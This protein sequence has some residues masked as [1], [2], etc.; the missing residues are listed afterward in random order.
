MKPFH[1]L[2]RSGQIARY[3]S[4]AEQ[5]LMHYELDAQ[6]IIPLQ[7]AHNATFRIDAQGEADPMRFALRIQHPRLRSSRAINSELHWLQAIAQDTKLVVPKPV[8]NKQGELITTIS[9]EGI[10][11]A[12]HCI[13]FEWVYGI[14]FRSQL[15]VAG[16]EQAGE[17]MA[18]LHNHATCYSPPAWFLRQRWDGQGLLGSAL[19]IDIQK[20][21]NELSPSQL[22]TLDTATEQIQ[23]ITQELGEGPEVFNLI[24]ADFHEANYLFLNQKIRA[25]DFDSCG[26][27]YYLYDIGVTFSTLQHLPN[28]SALRAAFLRGYRHIR[29]LP[30]KHEECIQ[31]FIGARLLG[32]ILLLAHHVREPGF[33]RAAQVRIDHQVKY[34][35]ALLGQSNELYTENE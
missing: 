33:R 4:L 5:T 25:I 3:R 20:S 17:F 11:E 30:L 23:Q 8:P 24:H 12:R 14:F 29:S 7:Y 6:Q 22:Y 10:P 35:E 15:G 28:F 34:L 1:S 19:Q 27:G 2:T 9:V 13:L 18:T 32:N 21:R 16:L 31:A 26:W